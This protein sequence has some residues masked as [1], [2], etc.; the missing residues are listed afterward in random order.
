MITNMASISNALI[1]K[2]YNPSNGSANKRC[3]PKIPS[4]TI[5]S[6]LNID[7]DKPGINKKMEHSHQRVTEH[8]LLTKCQQ[9]NIF[10]SLTCIIPDFFIPSE[11]DITDDLPDIN[12]KKTN[13]QP[14]D[15]YK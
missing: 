2:R 14:A 5:S 7:N 6:T 9:K 13:G 3:V 11:I 15:K 12:R 1:R 10:P 4:S 8:F